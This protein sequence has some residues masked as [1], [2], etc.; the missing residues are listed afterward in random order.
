[1]VLNQFKMEIQF[2]KT[3]SS[4][5]NFDGLNAIFQN[6][7][8]RSKLPSMQNYPAT[9]EPVLSGHSRI[10][11]TKVLTKNGSLI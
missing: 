4:F 9:K 3:A 7:A 1:M 11:K 6:S 5:P 10:D 8:G 2:L